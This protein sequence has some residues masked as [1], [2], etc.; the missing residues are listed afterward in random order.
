L[1]VGTHPKRCVRRLSDWFT[2]LEDSEMQL[3][4]G[5]YA[6]RRVRI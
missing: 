5:L 1:V 3:G 4:G 6:R 2:G